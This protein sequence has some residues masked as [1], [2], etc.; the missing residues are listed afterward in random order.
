MNANR[1]FITFSLSE[2]TY[3]SA[4]QLNSEI[5]EQNE[6]REREMPLVQDV[7]AKVKEL[8]QT[9]PSLNNHQMSLK[10]SIRKMKDKA[11]EMDE[12]VWF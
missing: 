6:S 7:D 1:I 11:K 2:V 8:R 5:A 9:I 10:A 3:S 4:L 12:K